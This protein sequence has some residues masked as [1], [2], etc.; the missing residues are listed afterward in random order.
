MMRREWPWRDASPL[1]LETSLSQVPLRIPLVFHPTLREV[2][3]PAFAVLQ[4]HAHPS[5]RAV[6]DRAKLDWDAF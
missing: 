4:K 2:I 6:D 3:S 1:L 5:G